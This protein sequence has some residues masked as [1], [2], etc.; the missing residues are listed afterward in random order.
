M[1]PLPISDGHLCLSVFGGNQFGRYNVAGSA[2]NS[3][4]A[5]DSTGVLQNLVGTS[6]LTTGFDI[7][8]AIP[9]PGYTT[10]QAGDVW[11]FQLWYRDTPAGPGH[12]NL[13]NAATYYF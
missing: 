9:I 11:H 2:L 13:S 12:S 10:I 5:F 4:G 8:T 3:I 1:S 6:S 7:P